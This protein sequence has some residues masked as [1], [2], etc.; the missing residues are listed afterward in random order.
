MVTAMMKALRTTSC[1]GSRSTEGWREERRQ[2]EEKGKEEMSMFSYS[3]NA[4]SLPPSLPP[5]LPSFAVGRRTSI[6]KCQQPMMAM[7]VM[8]AAPMP[9]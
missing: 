2:R 5:F 9:T 8:S 6:W 3:P 1:R 4:P 7:K